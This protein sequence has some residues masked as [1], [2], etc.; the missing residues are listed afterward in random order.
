MANIIVHH[1]VFLSNPPE[2]QHPFFVHHKELMF[3]I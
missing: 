3:E 2:S 1:G